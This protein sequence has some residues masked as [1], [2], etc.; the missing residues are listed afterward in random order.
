MRRYSRRAGRRGDLERR[1]S[2]SRRRRAGGDWLI[3]HIRP[4]YTSIAI[5][6]GSDL[7]FFRTAAE[8][9]PEPLADVVHQTAMYY[10]DRLSVTAYPA[11]LRRAQPAAGG[12]E[13]AV[14]KSKRD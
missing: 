6:R 4:E 2:L 5:M 9:D 3:V 10:Q 14:R 7:I 1:Q 11:S 13:T 12:V 8:G